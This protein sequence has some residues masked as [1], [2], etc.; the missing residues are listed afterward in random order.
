MRNPLKT[1]SIKKYYRKTYTSVEKRQ[2]I[3][4]G[5]DDYSESLEKGI[6]LVIF[7]CYPD[8]IRNAM[9]VVRFY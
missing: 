5:I 2:E 3:S 6:N 8:E 4:V 1:Y 7:F 9:G